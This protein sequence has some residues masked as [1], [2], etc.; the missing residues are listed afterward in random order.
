MKYIRILQ[1]GVSDQPCGKSGN[2]RQS[3]FPG[4]DGCSD[5]GHTPNQDS[6]PFPT[7]T[8]DSALGGAQLPAQP[9][10]GYGPAF[11]PLNTPCHIW[12]RSFDD[13]GYGYFR[14]KGKVIRAHVHYYV[15]KFGRVPDGLELDHTCRNRACVNPDHL[16][17]VTHLENCRRGRLV[18]TGMTIEKAR[19]I[20]QLRDK[21][22]RQKELAARFG[23]GVSLVAQIVGNRCWKDSLPSPASSPSQTGE[24]I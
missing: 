13:D 5:A 20:R 19:E 3:A 21:G 12:Q 4:S 2:N 11:T 15:G 1:S 23:I 16:E 6:P 18:K 8:Y 17:A 22:Y 9:H 7:D 24:G 14:H 10:P